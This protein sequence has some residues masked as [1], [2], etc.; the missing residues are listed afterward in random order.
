M[1]ESVTITATPRPDV[2]NINGKEKNLVKATTGSNT[3]D[4]TY[5]NWF[6]K[7]WVP[8]SAEQTEVAG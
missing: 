3:K 5:K 7:V 4:E 2:D 8:T 1:T 6:T